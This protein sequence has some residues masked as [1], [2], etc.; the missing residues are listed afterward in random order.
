MPTY[1]YTA[2]DQEGK[3]VAGRI[4]ADDEAMVVAELRKRSLII[5]GIAQE[6]EPAAA[7][8]AV[9]KRGGGKV[10]PEDLVIFT[11]QF[12]TMV[13]AG[14]PILQSL[15]ALVEQTSNANLKAA[16]LAINEDIQL[17]SSLS[18]A[19]EKHPRIFDNLYVNMIRVGESGG[20]LTTILER[21]AMYQEKSEWL[22]HKVQGAMIYPAVVMSM[23][24]L[25]T[26]GLLIYVV[27]TFAQ[28]YS[29]LGSQ[30]PP[31][32]QLLINFSNALKHDLLF[33]A[34]GCVA[35][36]FLFKRYRKTPAGH[37]QTDSLILKI[38]VFGELVCKVTISRF[39]RT[40]STLSQ[41][42]VPILESLEIVGKT[43]G[44]RVIELLVEDVKASVKEGESISGPLSKS[45]VFPL[46]VTRM[47]SIGEKSGQMD[48][49]LSKVA[50]FYD[51]QV[52]TAVESLTKLIEPFIIVFLG[53]VVGFIVIAL[54]LPILT[55]ASL[56]H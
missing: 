25:I 11:R 8:K 32:T 48:K 31:V 19:F 46:M 51:E 34:A 37:L 55:M 52:D 44:N 21:V 6:Q 38:P 41:S 23:A 18:S 4:S 27:P 53:V 28:I 40:L 24:M 5:L 45:P 22:R 16:L 42:G 2:R 54:L 43:C 3:D 33:I 39:C 35:A 1:S 56:I 36:V 15:E 13:D 12:A 30:L 26:A 10:K 50:E 14:I 47:I 7:K 17:G 20:V 49:M 9:P 29:S